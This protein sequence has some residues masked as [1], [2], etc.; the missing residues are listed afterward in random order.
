MIWAL[1]QGGA[2]GCEA[3]R[4][5][6]GG[7]WA[8]MALISAVGAL[9]VAGAEY[10][11][12]PGKQVIGDLGRYVVNQG[13]VF[14]DIARRFDLGYTA[15][16]TANPGVDTW[17]PRAA[18]EITIPSVYILPDAPRQGIVINLSQWRLFYFPPGGDRVETFPLGL[19]VIGRKTPLG[20]TRVVAKEANPAWYPPP[21][22]RAERPELPAM[23]PP[24]PENPLGA[25]ALHLGWR[26]YG[27]HGTHKTDAGG[28]Y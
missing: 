19:G 25:Y 26:S 7:G 21:S 5:W 1:S 4:E 22:I 16:V 20:G 9:Q 15:L 3:A 10:A 6:L 2:R 13:D 23:V 14:P 12:A 18:R 27:I 24:G 28:R 8:G 11:V 17:A